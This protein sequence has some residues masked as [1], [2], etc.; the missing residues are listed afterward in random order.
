MSA[1]TLSLTH[2]LRAPSER[3]GGGRPPL[4]LLLHG[5]GGSESD[6]FAHAARLDGRFLV[7]SARAPFETGAG[8]Y[9][10]FNIGFTPRGIVADGSQLK[11]SYKLLLRFIDELIETYGADA[12]RAYLAGFSQGAVMSMALALTRPEK[13]AGVAAMS[14]SF[15]SQVPAEDIDAR[16][17]AGLRVLITHG[18]NDAVLPVGQS[19]AAFDHLKRL[20]VDV[21]YREYPAGHEVNAEMVRDVSFWLGQSLDARRP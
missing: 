6:L 15:P 1:Q 12:G 16:S 5:I 14:G 4:L 13:I 18:L 2:L 10:W 3:A 21:T 7:A 17:L 19:R 8:A 11:T 9:G 20:P